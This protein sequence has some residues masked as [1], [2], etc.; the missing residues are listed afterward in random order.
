MEINDKTIIYFMT[1]EKQANVHIRRNVIHMNYFRE[2]D[3]TS[4]EQ[5]Q[6]RKK[7]ENSLLGKLKLGVQEIKIK[8]GHA[9]LQYP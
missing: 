7:F 4:E 1:T 9:T 3:E 2:S 5:D 6:D 8:P